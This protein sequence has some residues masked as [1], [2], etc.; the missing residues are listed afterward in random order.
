MS[1]VTTQGLKS[2]FCVI[3]ITLVGVY[4][5]M[6]SVIGPCVLRDLGNT[7]PDP[8]WAASPGKRREKDSL[9][10][11]FPFH[12][13]PQD[14]LWV[15]LS[16]CRPPLAADRHQDCLCLS[17]AGIA[18][19]HCSPMVLLFEICSEEQPHTPSVLY[20]AHRE[21]QCR[22]LKYH[23]SHLFKGYIVWS[24]YLREE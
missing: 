1:D 6:S 9:L 19:F 23:I 18:T 7:N 17:G 14:W 3:D 21:R 4:D 5:V 22:N 12:S 11:Q 16:M 15:G 20:W 10:P 13:P 2:K 8:P 24:N